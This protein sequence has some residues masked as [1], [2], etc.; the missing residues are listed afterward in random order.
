MQNMEGAYAQ[1]CILTNKR[2]F[3]I[4][5][6]K[7]KKYLP[8]YYPIPMDRQKIFKSSKNNLT[9]ESNLILK[10]ISIPFGP[11]LK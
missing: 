8:I 7:K 2:S 1:F 6:L 10:I 9:Y 11:Y 4:K 5:N 3:L